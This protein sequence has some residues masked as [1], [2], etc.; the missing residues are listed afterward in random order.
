LSVVG[1]F[2]WHATVPFVFPPL[3]TFK[4]CPLLS[5]C[6]RYQP[7]LPGASIN[8]HKKLFVVGVLPWQAVVPLVFP[9]PDILRYYPLLFTCSLK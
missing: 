2:P 3:K 9:P 8:F 6:I 1:V 4:Y 7:G 5:T